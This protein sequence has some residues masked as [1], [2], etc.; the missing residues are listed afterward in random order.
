M[1]LPGHTKDSKMIIEFLYNTYKDHI[2]LSILNQYTPMQ[3]LESY[4]ELN[5]RVTKREYD[6]VIDYAIR[7]GVENAWIQEGSTATESFIP[8]F[9]EVGDYL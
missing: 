4:P 1:V 7:L 2:Y 9:D 6:K 8:N 5:R 3:N